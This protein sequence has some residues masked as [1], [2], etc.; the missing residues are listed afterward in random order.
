M[1]IENDFYSDINGKN[2]HL[3]FDRIL[4]IDCY[5]LLFNL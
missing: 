2:P 3:T 4:L 1:E 5:D